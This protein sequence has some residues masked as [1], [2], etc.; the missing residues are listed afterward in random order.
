MKKSILLFL[1]VGIMARSSFGMTPEKDT[2]EFSYQAL[3]Q[4]IN[5][6]DSATVA[7][8]LDKNKKEYQSL[9]NWTIMSPR[10]RNVAT[11][12]II[13]MLIDNG[14]D[15]NVLGSQ[16]RTPLSLAVIDVDEPLVKL[17]L[18]KGANPWV[19]EHG[20][21]ALVYASHMLQGAHTPERKEAAQTIFDL[22]KA[23]ASKFPA[24]TGN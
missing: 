24:P 23:A 14:A 2:Q 8:L 17:L 13:K 22:V 18:D 16:H 3:K 1:L 9:L 11:L 19:G 6:G 5:R 20:W 4:A 12:E 15:V 21:T 7:L 10:S